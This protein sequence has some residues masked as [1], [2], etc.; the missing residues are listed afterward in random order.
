MGLRSP[1]LYKTSFLVLYI[2]FDFSLSSPLPFLVPTRGFAPSYSAGPW[3]CPCA[4]VLW[5]VVM[6]AFNTFTERC[7]IHTKGTCLIED[8]VTPHR[9]KINMKSLED[10]NPSWICFCYYWAIFYQVLYY[11]AQ[12]T[13]RSFLLYSWFFYCF[14]L[15]EAQFQFDC[16]HH[17]YQWRN[18]RYPI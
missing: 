1:A 16:R 13:N 2:W 17:H 5:F 15:D 6:S 9:D 4:H 3:A 8:L 7:H 18:K 12:D 14:L 10:L 11:G